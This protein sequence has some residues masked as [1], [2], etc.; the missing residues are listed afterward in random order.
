MGTQPS[1][2][3]WRAAMFNFYSKKSKKIVSSVII[4]L[5]VLAMII[6]TIASFLY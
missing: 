5:L 3:F 6:P 2:W 4:I 1:G